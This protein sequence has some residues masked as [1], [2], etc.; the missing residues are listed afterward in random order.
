[1]T[2][3]FLSDAQLEG[4]AARLLRRYDSL[5]GAVS[6]PPVPVERILEDVLDL[7]ILWDDISEPPNQSILAAL[8]PRFE[9]RRLQ[10]IQTYAPNRHAGPL[11]HRPGSRSGDIGMYT[12]I[13]GTWPSQTC[14]TLVGTLAASIGAPG[15]VRTCGRSRPIDSWGS[16]SCLQTCS[17][18][19]LE[20]ST[21]SV[22]PC[23][24]GCA[25]GSR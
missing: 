18:K 17:W 14:L 16:F 10:R 6:S 2:T 4:I 7:S 15:P 20:M 23:S 9:D 21:C 8:D 5:F 13:M 11:L 12:S 22:G 1:M 19:R 24:M 3:K 25:T